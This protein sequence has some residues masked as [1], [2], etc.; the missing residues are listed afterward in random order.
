MKKLG[1]ELG[2]MM[3]DEWKEQRAESGEQR[4]K[5]KGKQPAAGWQCSVGSPNPSA[6]GV[7]TLLARI[8]NPCALTET[9]TTTQ[10]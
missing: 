9:L 6:A 7:N 1:M 8:C 3:N 2:I 10:Q 4:A 5:G